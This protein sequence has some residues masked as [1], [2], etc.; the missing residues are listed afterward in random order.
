MYISTT[1]TH[2]HIQTYIIHRDK[3]KIRK[4]HNCMFN[5]TTR[6][7]LRTCNDNLG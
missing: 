6:F 3:F 1:Y 5:T 4:F 2:A 7:E